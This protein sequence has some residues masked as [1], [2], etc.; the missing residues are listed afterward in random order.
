M[1]FAIMDAATAACSSR[2]QTPTNRRTAATLAL[3]HSDVAH[4]AVGRQHGPDAVLAH[5][6]ERHGRDLAVG[7]LGAA[8]TA[9]RAGVA[10]R[11]AG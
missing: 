10:R 1:Q 4:D 2:G 9:R 5:D 3:N 7:I 8:G 6:G 11:Q